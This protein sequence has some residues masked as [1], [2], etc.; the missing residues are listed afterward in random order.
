MT[1]A[2]IIQPA[3]TPEEW[4][5]PEEPVGSGQR[6]IMFDGTLVRLR[7]GEL[8]VNW[9]GAAYDQ[10]LVTLSPRARHAVA[11]LCL[12]GQPF[13]F[14]HEEVI[15]VRES[16]EDDHAAYCHAATL[17]IVAQKLAA[18]LPK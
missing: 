18:M 11:A 4:V 17:R 10:E 15:A 8:A 9:D 12:D 5:T 3:L 7:D 2:E 6:L 1:T 13:G 16:A 14:T